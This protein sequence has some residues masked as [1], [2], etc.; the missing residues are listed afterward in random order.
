MLVKLVQRV[1]DDVFTADNQRLLL[2]KVKSLPG[3]ITG[4]TLGQMFAD[5][6]TNHVAP[7]NLT[8]NTLDR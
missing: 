7:S 4:K 8:T 1:L 2:E 3:A 5:D 6:M